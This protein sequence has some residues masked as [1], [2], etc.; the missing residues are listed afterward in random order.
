MVLLAGITLIRSNAYNLEKFACHETLRMINS[1]PM[2]TGIQVVVIAEAA[3]GIEASYI[4]NHIDKYARAARI[5]IFYVRELA[6]ENIGVLKDKNSEELYRY[7]LETALEHNI[8]AFANDLMT[9][10]PENTARE[11]LDRL[12]EMIRGYH[13]DQKTNKI[14]SKV[15][16][17][18]NDLVAAL[19]Q[20]LYWTNVF[21]KSPRYAMFKEEIYQTAPGHRYPFPLIGAYDKRKIG[22]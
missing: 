1:H 19:N 2:L 17:R 15:E 18:P 14:T 10:H 6:D 3:P 11:E 20:L 9:V 22:K 4:I 8:L 13:Y 16:G 5:R 21:W 12:A 7:C